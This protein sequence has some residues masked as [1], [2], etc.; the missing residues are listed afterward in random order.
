[1]SAK[2]P[3][4]KQPKSKTRKS[5]PKR[6][7]KRE[8]IA[9]KPRGRP[10]PKGNPG[11]PL[12]TRNFKGAYL[13]ISEL[14]KKPIIIDGVPYMATGIER[15]A[16]ERFMIALTLP[17]R[18]IAKQMAMNAIEGRTDGAHEQAIRQLGDTGKLNIRITRDLKE[19]GEDETVEHK[20]VRTEP[21]KKNE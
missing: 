11:R 16:Y 14:I 10:F 2:Q 3:K 8:V 4:R 12:G 21:D 13:K 20:D 7:E 19:N 18:S 5:P 9:K 15:T 1:V 6:D 17:R